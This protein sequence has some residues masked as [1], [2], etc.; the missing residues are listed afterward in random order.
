[1]IAR[2]AGTDSE[3]KVW[4]VGI[5]ILSHVP[6]ELQPRP[7]ITEHNPIQPMLFFPDGNSRQF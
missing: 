4:L 2:C 6:V 7:A 3:L 1:M 5:P